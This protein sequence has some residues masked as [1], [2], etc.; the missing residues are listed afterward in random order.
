MDL[1]KLQEL[2]LTHNEALTYQAL[3]GIG[4]TKTGA[5]VKKTG[6]HRVLIYD[7]L[8]SLIKK[9]LASYVIKENIKYFQAADPHRL[10]DFV[11]EKREIAKS[12]LPELDLLRQ[13][14]KSRQAVSIY[15]GIRGLT[16]A[17][18]TMLHELSAKDYHYVF[19][20]GNMADT[21]GHY[22]TIF[23]EHKRKKRIRT[24]VI[25][26]TAFRKRRE[27]MMLTYGDIRF[28]PLSY[29]PTDTWIYKDKVLIVT[30]TAQPPIAVLIVNQETANSYK[31][32]FEGYW[33]KAKK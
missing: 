15:E 5:I 1:M 13:E 26:D 31:K 33:K 24:K 4:E 10:V 21:M 8:E 18:N 14:A 19:A 12:I 22:Y 25:Y 11:D 29:F 23:Q 9:G 32:L 27:V 2:G 16:A 3:L 30:Y 6:M 7:A 28:Y 20:S 17:M